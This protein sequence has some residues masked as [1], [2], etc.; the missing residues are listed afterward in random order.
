LLKIFFLLED[1]N[2]II[3]TNINVKHFYKSIFIYIT[4]K[5]IEFETNKKKDV[6]KKVKKDILQMNK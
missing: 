1:F 2:I 5:K 4:I 6:T 3:I